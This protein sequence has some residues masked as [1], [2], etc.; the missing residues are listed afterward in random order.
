MLH[1][2]GFTLDMMG[3][4]LKR[5]A[6]M[7]P[8]RHQCLRVLAYLADRS[9]RVVSQKELIESC[10][11]HSRHT[12]A[13]SLAQ[14]IK[15]IREA[16]ADQSI[17]RTVPRQG[18]IFASPVTVIVPSSAGPAV[19]DAPTLPAPAAWYLPASLKSLVAARFG[20]DHSALWLPAMVVLVTAIAGAAW[21]LW[22]GS[23]SPRNLTMMA[24]PTIA[25]LPFSGQGSGAGGGGA[26][27]DLAKEITTRLLRVPRGYRIALRPATAHAERPAEPMVAG[28][29]LDAR[30]I[31]TGAMRREGDIT[32][33]NV[34]LIEA[35]TG[36]PLWAQ[37]FAYRPGEPG[38]RSRVTVQIARLVTERLTETES[39][40]PLPADAK[41]DHYAIMGRA[42]WAGERDGRMI[43][44]AM[45]LFKKGVETDP[46]SVPALQGYARA[47]ISAVVGGHAPEEQRPLWLKE[48]REAIDRVIAQHRR[49]YGAY[50]LR[51]SLHRALGE[52]EKAAK[53]LEQ[54]LEIN[55]D[56]AEAHAEL[57]RVMIEL[58]LAG[59]AV[60]RIDEAIRLSPTDFAALSWWQLWAGLAML[61]AGNYE[62]ALDRLLRAEQ[63]NPANED[64]PPWL[65]LAYAGGGRH[66][67]AQAV[68]EVYLRRKPD[69][70]VAGWKRD[71]A[72]DNAAVTAQRDR[73]ARML[74]DL[75][76]P[77]G[78]V[79]TG[80]VQ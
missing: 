50:R 21:W 7:V 42:L 74:R 34:Q 6:E 76:V 35:E 54:A 39:R 68:M 63:A 19:E 43:L 29:Q 57:G 13:N 69:F 10:W 48:A 36:R 64:L 80:S 60:E 70:T 45:A 33:L 73:I 40:R 12:N 30:Y 11:E 26:D 77:E 71:H 22:I 56:Y 53:A 72:S 28:R 27:A 75:G 59:K 78:E 66:D 38:A 65:A 23:G 9:G 47:K 16:L 25:V 44:A 8:L 67:K 2:K 52:W 4:A 37:P 51:G 1:F 17:I 58:G 24:E 31:V 15:E 41:A 62:A 32:H 46:N 79:R 49:N 18:Y 3:P 61:H 55:A 20:S 14:C 5:G